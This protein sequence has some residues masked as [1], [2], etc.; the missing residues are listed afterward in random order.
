MF[1]NIEDDVVAGGGGGGGGALALLRGLELELG[2]GLGLGFEGGSCICADIDI[3]SRVRL[4]LSK[5][6]RHIMCCVKDKC[7][8]FRFLFPL[9]ARNTQNKQMELEGPYLTLLYA[10]INFPPK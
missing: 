8:F 5:A 7:R 3:Y 1:P 6:L 4:C 2:L 9:V 10:I